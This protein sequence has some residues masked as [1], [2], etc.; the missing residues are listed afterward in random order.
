VPE[1]LRHCRPAVELR[2]ECARGV[3]LFGFIKKS[4]PTDE[5]ISNVRSIGELADR[6]VKRLLH[7]ERSSGS[8]PAGFP[9]L[10]FAKSVI[11]SN[12]AGSV[13]P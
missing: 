9:K 8:P 1:F 5:S 3:V 7:R 4:I 10:D 2:T 13:D 6:R 12:H 11:S